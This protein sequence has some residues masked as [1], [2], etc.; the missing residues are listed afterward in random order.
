MNEIDKKIIQALTDNARA[1]LTDLARQLGIA[2]TTVQSRIE[3][4]EK[5]GTI[6]GYTLRMGYA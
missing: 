5:A 1:P 6:R 2:R 4:L 3:R